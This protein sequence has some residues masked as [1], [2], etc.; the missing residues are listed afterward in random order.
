MM[1]QLQ[2]TVQRHSHLCKAPEV[3]FSPPS[4]RMYPLSQADAFW[5]RGVITNITNTTF[6]TSVQFGMAPAPAP[7][8]SPMGSVT[9]GK[10]ILTHK[11][12]LTMPLHLRFCTLCHQFQILFNAEGNLPSDCRVQDKD[13]PRDWIFVILSVEV[14]CSGTP[15]GSDLSNLPNRCEVERTPVLRAPGLI[16][17]VSL[18]CNH[19][20][21]HRLLSPSRDP[22]Y[23][24][25]SY[26]CKLVSS[27]LAVPTLY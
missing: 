11:L 25:Q 26:G 4:P 19:L 12:C 20:H 16:S 22:E 8:R 14:T 7:A 10:D 6:P 18:P 17:L 13:G 23:H 24:S 2:N 27:P 3:L 21:L 15:A 9:P 1:P 5:R